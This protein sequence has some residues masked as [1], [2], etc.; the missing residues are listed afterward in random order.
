MAGR[1][2]EERQQ[3]PFINWKHRTKGGRQAR[4]QV[5]KALLEELWGRK[6]GRQRGRA[7]AIGSKICWKQ[8]VREREVRNGWTG[9]LP[10]EAQYWETWGGSGRG[11]GEEEAS[12]NWQTVLRISYSK[13]F[14]AREERSGHVGGKKMVQTL[15]EARELNWQALSSNKA[16]ISLVQYHKPITRPANQVE[17]TFEAHTPNPLTMKPVTEVWGI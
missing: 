9:V 11:M 12:R 5:V 10:I 4:I 14:L 17:V 8:M 7:S 13:S 16:S 2:G 15:Q 6:R 1:E 3:N